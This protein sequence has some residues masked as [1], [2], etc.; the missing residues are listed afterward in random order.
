MDRCDWI[1]DDRACLQHRL[2]GL[3]TCKRHSP[4]EEKEERQVSEGLA[5]LFQICCAISMPNNDKNK[6]QN[7]K[8]K[9]VKDQQYYT[10][11]RIVVHKEK[12]WMR[13]SQRQNA[14][15]QLYN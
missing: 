13:R 11:L 12:Q 4:P 10:D 14:I 5:G 8:L 7:I 9:H 1:S 6:M 3:T 15:R 2:V